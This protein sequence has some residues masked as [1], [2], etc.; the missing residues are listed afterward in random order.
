MENINEMSLKNDEEA[1]KVS[2]KLKELQLIVQNYRHG[3]GKMSNR[4]KNDILVFHLTLNS[5]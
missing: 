3:L 1:K 2:S 4:D 5:F